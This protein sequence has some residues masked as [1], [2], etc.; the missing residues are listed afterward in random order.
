MYVDSA[1]YKIKSKV[2]T[3]HLLRSGYRKDGK[4]YLKH[5]VH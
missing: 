2:Y 5:A 4:V 3:R 1:T